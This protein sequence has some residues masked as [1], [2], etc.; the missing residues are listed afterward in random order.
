MQ[1]SQPRSHSIALGDA[2]AFNHNNAAT[3]VNNLVG[4]NNMG[5]NTQN[6]FTDE[7]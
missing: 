4:F 3:D 6:V 2:P 1:A 7:K 5:I